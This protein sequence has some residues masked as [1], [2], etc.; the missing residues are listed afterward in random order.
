[1]VWQYEPDKRNA[2]EVI[3][4]GSGVFRVVGRSVERMVIQTDWE[5]EEALSFM[6]HKMKKAGVDAALEAAGAK[7][8]DEIQ[9]AD[10][11]FE[12]SSMSAEDIFKELD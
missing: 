6:Q 1:M 5:N 10:F 11:S 7:D 3:D 2:F 9:I 12:F 8:G 4:E